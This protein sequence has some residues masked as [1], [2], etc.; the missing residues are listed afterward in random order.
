MIKDA[1]K[2]YDKFKDM[3]IEFIPQGSYH[4]NTNVRNRGNTSVADTTRKHM[5]KNVRTLRVWRVLFMS[6]KC[7]SFSPVC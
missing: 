7:T 5:D 2:S 1:I 4:N 6:D 3:D